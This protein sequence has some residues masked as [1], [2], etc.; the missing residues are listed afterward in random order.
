MLQISVAAPCNDSG[1]TSLLLA[2]LQTFPGI[3]SAAKFTTIYREEQFCPVGNSGC[4][5]HQLEGSYLLCEDPMVLGEPDTDTGKLVRAGA[6]QTFWGVTRPEGYSALVAMLRRDRFNESTRLV[7]EGNTI[8]RH[9]APDFLFFVVNPYLRLDSWKRDSEQ[10][11]AAAN[12]IVVNSFLQDTD[13]PD[14]SR[15]PLIDQALGPYTHKCIHGEAGTRLDR[16]KD[17]R[18]FTAI[19]SLLADPLMRAEPRAETSR[20]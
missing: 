16:W 2:I 12:F 14:T 8:L 5:C 3:F 20:T 18:P 4:P 1:K 15:D 19:R 6:L 10:L 9:L 17:Q 11:L 7:T 13:R